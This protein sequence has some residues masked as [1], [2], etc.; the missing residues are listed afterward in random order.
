MQGY[1]PVTA[2][3][4]DGRTLEGVAKNYTNYD[5]QLTDKTGRLYLLQASD[6]SDLQFRME[7]LMPK[8]YGKRLSRDEVTD[9]LAYLSQQS[10]RPVDPKKNQNRRR[11]AAR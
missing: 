7:S 2:K 3:L 1:L 10:M 11:G 5:L 4:K 8:D 9:L 6:L